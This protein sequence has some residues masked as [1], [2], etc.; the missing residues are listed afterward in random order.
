[1]RRSE[2]QRAVT[3]EFG[4]AYGAVLMADLVLTGLNNHTA[5]T[6]MDAGIPA[7]DVWNALC[8]TA[9]V[10]PERR[11]GVGRREPNQS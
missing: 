2:F 3:D 8:E 1:M 6:A 11:Y 5:Q 9:G 7:G 10:A 4:A